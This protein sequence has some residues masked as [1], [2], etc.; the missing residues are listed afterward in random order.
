MWNELSVQK[1]LA[2]P[3]SLATAQMPYNR[4]QKQALPEV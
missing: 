1:A 4:D 3:H 2:V